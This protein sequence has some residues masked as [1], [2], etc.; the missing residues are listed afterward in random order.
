MTVISAM[1]FNSNDGAIVSDEQTTMG[2]RTDYLSTKLNTIRVED[3]GITTIFGGTGASDV[4]YEVI[5]DSSVAISRNTENITE[6]RDMVN[7]VGKVMTQ[8]YLSFIHKKCIM[9]K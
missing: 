2:S 9:K 6:G 4:L 1:K 8:D 5:M 3:K 7:I